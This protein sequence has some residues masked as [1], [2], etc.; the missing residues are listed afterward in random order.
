[1]KR[2]QIAVMPTIGMVD[3]PAPPLKKQSRWSG[4]AW[5]PG[6]VPAVPLMTISRSHDS[7]PT[8]YWHGSMGVECPVN[9]G[10]RYPLKMNQGDKE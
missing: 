10:E 4:R 8:P 5:Q 1:M 9:R 6:E 3:L 7:A 2:K